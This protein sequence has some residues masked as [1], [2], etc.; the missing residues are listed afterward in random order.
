ME[1][2]YSQM[3]LGLF[4]AFIFFIAVVFIAICVTLLIDWIKS[5]V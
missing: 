5:W 4:L 2:N 3:F 1:L